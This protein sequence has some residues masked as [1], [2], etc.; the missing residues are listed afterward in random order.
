MNKLYIFFI[1]DLK[2]KAEVKKNFSNSI[3]VQSHWFMYT[4]TFLSSDKNAPNDIQ[5]NETSM[6]INRGMR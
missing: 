1:L 2:K 6:T 4:S 5:I 3:F